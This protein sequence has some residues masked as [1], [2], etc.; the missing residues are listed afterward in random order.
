MNSED[1]Q[2]SVSVFVDIR[3]GFVCQKCLSETDFKKSA[4]LVESRRFSN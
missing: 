4:V 1:S 3:V 2:V